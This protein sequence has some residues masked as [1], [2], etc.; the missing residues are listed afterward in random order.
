MKIIK[1]YIELT[2]ITSIFIVT[3]KVHKAHMLTNN[4]GVTYLSIR[5]STESIVQW[6]DKKAQL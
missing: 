5:G 3:S 6:I 4:L 1:P 2:P